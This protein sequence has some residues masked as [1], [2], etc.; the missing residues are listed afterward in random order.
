M[1]QGMMIHARSLVR[2]IS[3]ELSIRDLLAAIARTWQRHCPFSRV[4]MYRWVPTI[5]ESD[6][7]RALAIV[8]VANEAGTFP[9]TI[10]KQLT[11]TSCHLRKL[12]AS[13]CFR[14]LHHGVPVARHCLRHCR[15]IHS[16]CKG[17]TDLWHS[18]KQLA[19]SIPGNAEW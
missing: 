1:D 7:H 17:T 10:V 18:P 9:P 12:S 14:F 2:S 3:A 6:K 4:T 19:S 16:T 15:L 11:I 13:C 5:T 8:R